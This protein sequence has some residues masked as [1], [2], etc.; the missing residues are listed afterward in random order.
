MV[1]RPPEILI[2]TPETLNILL[3]SQGRALAPRRDRRGGPR[4]DPRRR[5]RQA[6]HPPD[7]RGRPPG[8]AV[9]RVPAGGAVGHRA[10]AGAGGPLRRRLPAGARRSTG[11]EPSYRRRPVAIVRSEMAKRY[12]LEVRS[13]AERPVA[14]APLA[15]GQHGRAVGPPS[16]EANLWEPLAAE[17]RER[18]RANRSTLIFANSRRT[19]EKMTRFLNDGEPEELAYSHHGSLSREIRA[20]VEERLKQGRLKGIVSTNSLELG[21]DIGALDEVVL[22]Q[23]PPSVAA[24]VQRIGRA[25]HQVGETSRGRLYPLHERDVLDAAVVARGVLD[26][27]IEELAPMR[28]ALD[29]LAQIILSMVAAEPWQVDELYDHLRAGYPYRHLER[30][31]FDLVLEMLAGRYADSRIRE[32]RPRLAYDRLDGTVRARPGTARLV[33]MSGGTIPDRGYFQLRRQDTMAKLGELDEEFVWERSIGDSFT[34]GAQSWRIRKITHNDVLV[35]PARKG[36]AMAPFWRAEARSRTFHL[37]QPHRR[38]PRARRAPSRAP[39]RRRRAAP[40]PARRAP[41]GRRRR[42]PPARAAG[43][44]AR[45][46]RRGAAPPPPP[47]GRE[48]GRARGAPGPRAGD[49]PLRLGRPGAAAAGAGAQGR[50]AG[51]ARLAARARARQR[52]GHRRPAAGLRPARRCSIWCVPTTSRSCWSASSSAAASLAP[53]FARTPAG[54]CCCRAPASAGARRCGSTASARR[55]SWRRSPRYDD[56][57]LI[58]ETW[59]TCL[60]D[61]FDLENLKLL[62]GELEAGAIRVSEC[63][64]SAASPFAGNLIWK[65]TNRLMYEDDVPEGERRRPARRPAAR[66]GL[67]L[68]AAAADPGRRARPLPAQAAPHLA[69]LLRRRGRRAGGV[70]QGA[71]GRSRWA[72]GTSCCAAVARDAARTRARRSAEQAR[73][74]ASWSPRRPSASCGSSWRAELAARACRPGEPGDRRH[75]VAAAPDGGARSHRRRPRARR[76]RSCRTRTGRA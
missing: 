14:A 5:R 35:S 44:S 54:R 38:V 76:A 69:G 27:D 29:V 20:V 18:I 16:E 25:G 37:S 62:L 59:R 43:P 31:Q 40:R 47:A 49:P 64:T 17:V 2:T 33:Y 57:P 11:G 45:R 65:Q 13:A 71:A 58:V 70:G 3:T 1:R 51:R 48:A 26:G 60:E 34:L 7:H 23:T 12:D 39:R 28:G 6:R 9:G 19:T 63:R 55:S 61:E 66:A 75:R 30:R 72:S 67:L 10:A 21:I 68:R 22:V 73:R 15:P 41:H 32:L 52:R 8:A 46:D 24:A 36:A 4:R 53:A 74:S 56:F 42:R 50:L